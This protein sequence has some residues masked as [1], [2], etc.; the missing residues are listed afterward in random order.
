[1]EN[2]GF[3]QRFHKVFNQ[4]ETESLSLCKESE[5]IAVTIN[6]YFAKKIIKH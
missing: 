2:K 3:T 1:M 6:I 4:E 5:E